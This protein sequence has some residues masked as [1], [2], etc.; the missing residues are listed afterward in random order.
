MV[1]TMGRLTLVMAIMCGLMLT[2]LSA[3]LRKPALAPAGDTMSA[4]DPPPMG[5]TTYNDELKRE[6]ALLDDLLAGRIEQA[7]LHRL[8]TALMSGQALDLPKDKKSDDAHLVKVLLTLPELIHDRDRNQAQG[9][10][11]LKAKYLFL[12][13]RFVE[14]STLMSEILQKEDDD[15]VR[16]WRARAIFFLGNPDL[17]VSELNRVIAHS[18]ERSQH[19]LDALYLI[20]AINYE[21]NDTDKKRIATG[22]DAWS[23]YLSLAEPSSDMSKEIQKAIVELKARLDGPSKDSHALAFDR[24]SPNAKNSETK[25]AILKAFAKEELLLA[26]K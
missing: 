3:C 19:G 16:N 5:A 8:R 13:R 24:F 26:L 14:A 12:N 7:R 11:W 21:S 20:G 23:R 9:H 18:G 2:H 1:S 15:L 25:N 4:I 10:A 6:L 17:A 22:I